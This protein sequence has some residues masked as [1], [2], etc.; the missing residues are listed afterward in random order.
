MKRLL[1]VLCVLV[2]A[3]SGAFAQFSFS[4]FQ[5]D[6]QAFAGEIAN[7]LP[8]NASI[9]NNW[10]DAYIGQLIGMPPHFGAGVTAGATTIPISAVTNLMAALG[11]TLPS[12]LSWTQNVGFPVP[13]A[14]AEARIGGFLLPFDLGLKVGYIDPT[15]LGSLPFTVDY[16]LVGGDVRFALVKE[17]ILLPA[18]SV[19]AGYT[20]MHG[21]IGIAGLLPGGITIGSFTFP[22]SS[23]HTLGFTNPS[24]NFAWDTNVIDLKVQISKSLLIITPYLGLGASWGISSAGGGLSSQMTVDGSPVTQ[25]QIDQINQV[26][27]QSITLSNPAVIVQSSV[28]GWSFRAWGGLSLNIFVLRL[29]LNAMY[30]ITS[31]ALG[32][33]LGARIQI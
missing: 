10:S 2:V 21:R 9:G 31:G 7:A 4:E 18:I 28:Q 13:A 20:F 16:L 14:T 25:S 19:G 30:D 6:F 1:V 27:G 17:D 8:F 29:D 3:A 26:T 11:V 12:D 24:L 32:A 33:S 22:D 23:T 15:W 5:T